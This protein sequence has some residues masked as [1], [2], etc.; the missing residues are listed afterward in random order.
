MRRLWLNA[1]TPAHR[2]EQRF[3]LVLADDEAPEQ[4]AE[5]QL[6][7][8]CRQFL[9]DLLGILLAGRALDGGIGVEIELAHL[10]IGFGGDRGDRR[11]DHVQLD[12]RASDLS[13]V[14]S[15]IRDAAIV[16]RHRRVP[17]RR[18]IIEMLL[19]QIEF[20]E[21]LPHLGDITCNGLAQPHLADTAG[22]LLKIE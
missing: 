10:A 9:R 3:Q 15:K 14:F 4:T 7:P 2:P 8:C 16:Q 22:G 21:G 1:L 11:L 5:L 17:R 20:E 18:R 12:V 19:D 13:D 6:A